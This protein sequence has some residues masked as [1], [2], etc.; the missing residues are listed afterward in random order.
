MHRV[1]GREFASRLQLI[2]FSLSEVTNPK[3][4][5]D[6]HVRII[7]N[8]AKLTIIQHK[9]FM[10]KLYIIMQSLSWDE[11]SAFS[12]ELDSSDGLFLL[13]SDGLFS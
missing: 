12:V 5:H 7:M 1:E 3:S 11:F 9:S 13:P 2:N 6:L 4:D 10:V 8:K